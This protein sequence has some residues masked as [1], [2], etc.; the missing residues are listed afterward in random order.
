MLR[1]KD[2]LPVANR[3]VR[4][5]ERRFNVIFRHE[6][7]PGRFLI[8]GRTPPHREHLF[9]RPE[10]LFWMPV[11]GETPLHV[12]VCGFPGQR[13]PIHPSVAGFTSD[14]FVHVDAVIEVD[15]VGKIVHSIP[16]N[17]LVL[18]Q[19]RT[20]GFEH[21]AVSPDLLVTVHARRC[22]RNTSKGA[23]FNGVVAIP[24]VDPE[25]A[26]VMRVTERDRLIKG[27]SFVGNIR[28]INGSCPTPGDS[29]DYENP[30]ENRQ[31]R[32]GVRCSFEDLRHGVQFSADSGAASTLPEETRPVLGLSE[33]YE[34]PERLADAT[35]WNNSANRRL[36]AAAVRQRGPTAFHCV[37]LK[38]H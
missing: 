7:T 32:D 25:S 30:S 16:S 29:S 36:S 21:L 19:A 28:R 8:R 4:K 20:D 27:D 18:T 10:E 6:L 14:A 15:E 2:L 33:S 37:E 3:T 23:H 26:H 22:W 11:T 38:E 5:F 12:H 24:A 34:C 9:A 13:H 1:Q 17:G 31:P 35:R